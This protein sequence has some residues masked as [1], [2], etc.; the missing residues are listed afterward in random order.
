M[1]PFWLQCRSK[2]EFKN[3]HGNSNHFPGFLYLPVIEHVEPKIV[4]ERAAEY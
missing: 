4:S 2:T 3:L 1:K